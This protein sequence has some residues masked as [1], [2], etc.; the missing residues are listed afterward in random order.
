[1]ILTIIVKKTDDGFEAEVPTVKGCDAW[2]PSEDGVLEKIMEIL[3]YYLK[4]PDNT[5]FKLDKTKDD[6]IIKK[7]KIGFDKLH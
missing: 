6:F 2:D 1:M 4:L 7:Y 5:K 3:R